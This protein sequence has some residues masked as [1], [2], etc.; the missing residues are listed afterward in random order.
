VAAPLPTRLLLPGR[1]R[2]SKDSGRRRNA[3]DKCLPFRPATH[4]ALPCAQV[5]N[6]D[7]P[8]TLFYGP[9]GAG[10]KT[11]ILALLREIYGAG[12]EKV[13]GPCGWWVGRRAGQGRQCCFVL[14]GR[15]LLPVCLPRPTGWVEASLQPTRPCGFPPLPPLPPPPCPAL[16]CLPLPCL[17]CPALPCSSRLSASPGR[18]SCPAGFWSWS[19]P[20]SAAATTWR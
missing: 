13:G 20:P 1:C 8:H 4:S 18:S 6:G 11:L 17:P 16:P 15:H 5:V 14:C 9:P 3:G 19:S 10:K 7:C 12:V 2:A